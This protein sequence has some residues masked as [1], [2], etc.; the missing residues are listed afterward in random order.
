[1]GRQDRERSL[2]LSKGDIAPGYEAD[3]VLVDPQSKFVIRAAESESHQ[4]YSPFEDVELTGRMKST[5]LRD[6]LIYFDGTIV[7]P[8]RGEYLSRPRA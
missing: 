6:A 7:G 2:L 8:P 3:I 4:G 1:L 5:S